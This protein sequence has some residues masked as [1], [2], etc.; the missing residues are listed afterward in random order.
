MNRY[1]TLSLILGVT[2]LLGLSLAARAETPAVDAEGFQTIFD[3]KT[4]DGWD[5]DPAS[6]SVEDGCITGQTSKEKPA[7]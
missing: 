6:G 7:P 2:V 5:G 3:G 1:K 4:F